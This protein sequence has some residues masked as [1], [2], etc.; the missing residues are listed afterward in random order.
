[1]ILWRWLSGTG[2][3]GEMKVMWIDGL[4]SEAAVKSNQLI[5]SSIYFSGE[6]NW[7]ACVIYHSLSST[8]FLNFGWLYTPWAAKCAPHS[9][10][11]IQHVMLIEKKKKKSKEIKQFS[12]NFNYIFILKMQAHIFST[13]IC[14]ESLLMTVPVNRLMTK[15][16]MLHKIIVKVLLLRRLPP[17]LTEHLMVPHKQHYIIPLLLPGKVSCSTMRSEQPPPPPHTH[18]SSLSQTAAGPEGASALFRQENMWDAAC[19]QPA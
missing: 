9:N 5:W 12:F 3:R 6:V 13:D 18:T 10:S 17:S 1:M 8:P 11:T 7:S 14:E 15:K 2:E 4:L 19:L 16:M